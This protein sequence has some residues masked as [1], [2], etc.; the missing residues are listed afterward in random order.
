[1]ATLAVDDSSVSHS[2]ANLLVSVKILCVEIGDRDVDC[3][4]SHSV[5][6]LVDT[7]CSSPVE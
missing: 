4:V 2:V 7:G 6:K 3:S 1:M 5:T